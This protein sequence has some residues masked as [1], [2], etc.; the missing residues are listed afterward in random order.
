MTEN[1]IAENIIE[2]SESLLNDTA[3]T[4]EFFLFLHL[5]RTVVEIQQCTSLLSETK[6]LN[7]DK[8]I[9]IPG[10]VNA[11]LHSISD[12]M[13]GISSPSEG[14]HYPMNHVIVSER[15]GN[16]HLPMKY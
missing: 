13:P 12:S 3:Q 15:H 5:E 11:G 8:E 7:R 10:E 2:Y 6:C 9:V 1:E 16:F 4:P 14:C